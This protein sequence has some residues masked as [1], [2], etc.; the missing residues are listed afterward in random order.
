MFPDVEVGDT[1]VFA[2]RIVQATPMFPGHFSVAH[3]FSRYAAYDDVSI[4]VIAP[5]SLWTQ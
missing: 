1:V 4:K 2:Y 5:A 3:V